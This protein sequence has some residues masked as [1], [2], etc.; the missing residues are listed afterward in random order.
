[1][2]WSS[3]YDTLARDRVAAQANV[4]GM[5][6]ALRRT[7]GGASVSLWIYRD[8]VRVIE[9]DSSGGEPRVKF[10]AD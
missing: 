4:A 2:P 6:D 10:L 1:V 8:R 9:G 7:S 5:L 3:L